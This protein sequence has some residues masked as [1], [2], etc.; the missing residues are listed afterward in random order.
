M[1]KEERKAYMKKW[2]ADH[3]EEERKYREEHREQ[4]RLT[5]K[6][7]YTR[8]KERIDE[9]HRKWVENNRERNKAYQREYY[10]KR[11]LALARKAVGS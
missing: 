4:I 7:Y 2:H 5:N 9:R 8:N 3:A 11:K 6:L 1:T 10:H